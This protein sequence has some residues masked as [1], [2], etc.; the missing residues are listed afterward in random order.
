ML[1]L[2]PAWLALL[3]AIAHP[4]SFAIL[5]QETA[6]LAFKTPTVELENFARPL[7]APV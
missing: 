3:T 6:Y 1:A 7:Q 2:T 5:N 4:G